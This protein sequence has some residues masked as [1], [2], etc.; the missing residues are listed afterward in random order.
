[1]GRVAIAAPGPFLQ[2]DYG[3][4]A[5]LQHVKFADIQNGDAWTALTDQASGSTTAEWRTLPMGL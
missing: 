5:A 1:M 4:A 2:L 3:T